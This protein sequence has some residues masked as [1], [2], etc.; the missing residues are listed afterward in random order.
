MLVVYQN[1][2]VSR[3]FLAEFRKRK[4]FLNENCLSWVNDLQELL[5]PSCSMSFLSGTKILLDI[6]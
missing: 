3:G 1:G 4:R 5:V 6:L 2:W